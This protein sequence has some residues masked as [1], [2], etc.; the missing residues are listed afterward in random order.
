MLL[1]ELSDQAHEMAQQRPKKGMR[2]G[3][4]EADGCRRRWLL[5]LD[6]RMSERLC[7]VLG[8]RALSPRQRARIS[9]HEEHQHGPTLPLRLGDDATRPRTSHTLVDSSE[10]SLAPFRTMDPASLALA[11]CSGACIRTCALTTSAAT[12]VSPALQ[13]YLPNIFATLIH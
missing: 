3:N 2:D 7:C 8:S 12:D 5:D 10:T 9:A 13:F 11:G 6:L 1:S 4:R